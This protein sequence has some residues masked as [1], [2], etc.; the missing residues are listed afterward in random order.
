MQGS[1]TSKL[2]GGIQCHRSDAKHHHFINWPSYAAV[3]ELEFRVVPNVYY[4]IKALCGNQYSQ[5]TCI[6][7]FRK[8]AS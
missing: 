7:S 8:S 4:N 3:W 2:V 6:Y 1:M 5:E